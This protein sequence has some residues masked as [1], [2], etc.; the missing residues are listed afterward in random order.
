[1]GRATEPPAQHNW[2]VRNGCQPLRTW[3]RHGKGKAQA[4]T[5]GDLSNQVVLLDWEWSEAWWVI[6]EHLLSVRHSPQLEVQSG[7]AR[8]PC[9]REACVC[10]KKADS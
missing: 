1:M 5:G 4:L 2:M 3:E 7:A 10:W 9:P 6:T 8:S